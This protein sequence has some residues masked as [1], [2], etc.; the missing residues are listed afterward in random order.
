MIRS[1]LLYDP[2]ALLPLIREL[3]GGEAVIEAVNAETHEEARLPKGFWIGGWRLILGDVCDR[4]AATLQARL[5]RDL[6]PGYLHP[7]SSLQAYVN[8]DLYGPA[9]LNPRLIVPRSGT[10]Q[11]LA[12]EFAKEILRSP[13]A[14]PRGHG[15]SMA[16][17]RLPVW[18]N[19]SSARQA[20]YCKPIRL[21]TT[22][23]LA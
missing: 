17:A 7:R 9:F 19:P 12:W 6:K 8:A 15:Q 11:Q 13:S 5:N 10:A 23:A 20:M 2:V 1:A 21:P 4:S 3:Q 22:C 18:S 14:P 16:L